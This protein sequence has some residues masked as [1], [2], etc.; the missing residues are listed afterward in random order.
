M[1]VASTVVLIRVLMDANELDTQQ[2]H[3]A[4]GWL[5]V[6]DVMT[7]VALVMIPTLSTWGSEPAP[8]GGDSPVLAIAVALLKLV[9]MVVV[10]LVAGARVV[11]WVL[12]K[13]TQLRSRELFTLTVLVFSI[14]I[15]A[16]ATPAILGGPATQVAATAIYNFI[17]QLLDWSLG[18]ALAVVLIVSTLLLLYGASRFGARKAAL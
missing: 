2:G 6:E 3:I 15:S 10:V 13:I 12:V 8:T 9:L 5:L 17:I 7:V 18:A 1:A 14:A 16:Y 4:V 11:P